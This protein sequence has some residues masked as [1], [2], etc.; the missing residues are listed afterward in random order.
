MRSEL[1][2]REESEKGFAYSRFISTTFRVSTPCDKQ[3]YA[4]LLIAFKRECLLFLLSFLRVSLVMLKDCSH[5]KMLSHVREWA[6]A[7]ARLVDDCC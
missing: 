4:L 1:L 7:G 2:K 6:S 3:V 5:R